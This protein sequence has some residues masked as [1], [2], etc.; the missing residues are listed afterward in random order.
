MI[1]SVKV[2][3]CSIQTLNTTILLFS[4][5]LQAKVEY[6]HLVASVG[7]GRPL[8]P[9]V[10]RVAS[11]N[12]KPSVLRRPDFHQLLARHGGDISCLSQ[13]LNT[14]DYDSFALGVPGDRV[15]KPQVYMLEFL[16]IVACSLKILDLTEAADCG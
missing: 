15:G 11:S 1:G 4:I 2:V 7:Q 14:T 5:H 3:P 8:C 9:G 10:I 12:S 13:E 16:F 6:D